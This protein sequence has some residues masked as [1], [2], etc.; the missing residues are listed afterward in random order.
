MNPLDLFLGKAKHRVASRFFFELGGFLAG[1]CSKIKNVERKIARETYQEGG[2]NERPIIL[3][4]PQT[5]LDKLVLEKG[6]LRTNPMMRYLTDEPFEKSHTV[7]PGTLMLL[8]EKRLPVRIFYFERGIVS[9]WSM[10][11][12]DATSPEI[13]IESITI[14]HTGLL[15][16]E[17]SISGVRKI[18]QRY[19]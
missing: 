11:D 6:F 4:A 14:E 13:P 1:G 16:M 17:M 7:A 5:S 2:L 15:E 18:V 10:V 12:L 19:L 3:A 8:N 9:E